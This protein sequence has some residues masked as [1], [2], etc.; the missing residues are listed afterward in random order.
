MLI[1]GFTMA[2][3]AGKLHY[4]IRESILSALPIVDEFIVALGDCDEDDNTLEI[5]LSIGDPKI[6]IYQRQWDEKLFF[7]GKIFAHETSFA[8]GQCHGDWCLYLQADEVLHQEEIA[9][10]KSH[11]MAYRENFAVDGFLM[12][13]VHFWG[14]YR[15]RINVHHICRKEI[16][17]VRNRIGCYSYVDAVSFRKMDNQKL[18]IVDLP[19]HIYHYGY[20]RHPKVMGLKREIQKEF[21]WG[22]D[23]TQKSE[24]PDF[25]YG[26]LGG[27]PIFKGTHPTVM[28]DWIG[29]FDWGNQLN[30]KTWKPWN[31]VL[32]P[33]H[34][35]RYRILTWIENNLLNGRTLFGFRNYFRLSRRQILA[36]WDD[37][38]IRSPFS[39]TEKD[40]SRIS[41]PV[42]VSEMGLP[43]TS[44]DHSLY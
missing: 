18:N 9:T 20:V 36:G 39:E 7:G 14:D 10:I 23:E 37:N 1:S 27:L 4:P 8:L 15:H 24:V 32:H 43:N 30:H 11:C 12:P 13:Y 29:K 17:L 41:S 21:H 44:M 22:F 3:N 33:Q 5:L 35:L 38:N 19:V 16:R 34:K 25:D 31:G 40:R 6:K 42:T 28:Q 2:R 26:P